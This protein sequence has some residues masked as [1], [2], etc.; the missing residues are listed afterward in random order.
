MKNEHQLHGTLDVWLFRTGKIL[1]LPREEWIGTITFTQGISCQRDCWIEGQE[2]ILMYIYLD[3]H[4]SE[5]NG[6]VA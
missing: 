5:E 4:K 6:T 2:H 1:E 3:G